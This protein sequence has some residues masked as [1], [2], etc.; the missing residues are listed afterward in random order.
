MFNDNDLMHADTL[1][2]IPFFR[3]TS[4]SADLFAYFGSISDK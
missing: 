1:N 2:P 3:E 4:I